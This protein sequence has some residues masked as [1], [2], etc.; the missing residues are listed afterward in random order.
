MKNIPNFYKKF[1]D[2]YFSS[3]HI[4]AMLVPFGRVKKGLYRLRGTLIGRNVDIAQFVFLEDSSPS[5]IQI[6]DY[7]DIGPRVTIVAHDSSLHCIDPEI[8]LQYHRV[9]IE[10]NA[11]IGAGAT[12]LPGVTIGEHSI[13]AA[14]A[15]VTKDVPPFVIVAGVPAKK[16]GTVEEKIAK[17]YE[18]AESFPN[19][20]NDASDI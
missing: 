6:E 10:R 20:P 1:S 11:Y 18:T 12:I 5:L 15:V 16:I 9:L 17:Y 2:V 7:V 14:G 13:V 3:V 19:E 4:L 8:P